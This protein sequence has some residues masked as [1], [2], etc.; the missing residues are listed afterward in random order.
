MLILGR[1]LEVVMEKMRL[2]CKGNIEILM[3]LLL[4]WFES[5]RELETFIIVI[6]LLYSIL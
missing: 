6:G 4:D 2:L 3:Y 5:I 1:G